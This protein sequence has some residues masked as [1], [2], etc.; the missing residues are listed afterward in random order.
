MEFDLLEH[1]TLS[2]T[3]NLIKF[4][5]TGSKISYLP[6]YNGKKKATETSLDQSVVRWDYT[7]MND[8][9]IYSM[10]K[11]ILCTLSVILGDITSLEKKHCTSLAE[12]HHSESPCQ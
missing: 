5:C 3:K 1:I 12:S 11:K 2:L 7:L 9:F 10:K 6:K 4:V 8:R